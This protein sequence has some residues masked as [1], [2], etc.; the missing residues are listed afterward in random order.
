MQSGATKFVQQ[1]LVNAIDYVEHMDLHNYNHNCKFVQQFRLEKVIAL[2]CR[3]YGFTQ[4]QSKDIYKIKHSII[5]K[6]GLI[7]FAF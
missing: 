6:P 7:Y 2:L 1:F 3:T 4:L 5:L